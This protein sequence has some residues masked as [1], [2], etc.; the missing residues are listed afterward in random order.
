[1]VDLTWLWFLAFIVAALVT[2]ILAVH[3]IA[4]RQIVRGI[5]IASVSIAVQ[6]LATSAL[7]TI[8]NNWN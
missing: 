5:A 1:M 7:A 4:K 8:I 3:C 2:M 6:F